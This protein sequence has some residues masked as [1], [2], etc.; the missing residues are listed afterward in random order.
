[1][2]KRRRSDFLSQERVK[3]IARGVTTYLAPMVGGKPVIMTIDRSG[4]VELKKFPKGKVNVTSGGVLVT[5]GTRI[6]L[7][8]NTLV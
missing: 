7:S 6:N 8:R 2:A 5:P 3:T 1:M 4:R